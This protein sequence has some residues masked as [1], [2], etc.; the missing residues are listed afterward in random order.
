MN[1]LTRMKIN[2][3]NKSKLTPEQRE[4]ANRF[5]ELANADD[6]EKE[7]PGLWIGPVLVIIVGF[8]IAICLI[9]LLG[10]FIS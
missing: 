9:A 1:E 6:K 4:T 10:V 5:I 2:R 8:V 7:N 3:I